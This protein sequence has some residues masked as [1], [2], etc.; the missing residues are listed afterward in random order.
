MTLRAGSI[1]HINM[2]V[3]NLKESVE[4]Y[5]KLFGF[6]LKKD[7]PDMASVIIGNDRIKL[8]LYQD[9]SLQ[10]EAGINHFG[11]HIDNF[12]EIEFLCVDLGVEVLYAG[13]VT[14]EEKTK[15]LYIVDP[16][17]YTIELS[18]TQGGGL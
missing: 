8:C 2:S 13:Q 18:K 9:P 3:K 16:N 7:Q 5:S 15:S 14:W 4:F 10:I 6:T 1:D 17:G 11:F 12:D